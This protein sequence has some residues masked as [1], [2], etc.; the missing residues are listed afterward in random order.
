VHMKQMDDVKD[1]VRFFG[2]SSR[3]GQLQSEYN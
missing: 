3:Y 1:R 2:S